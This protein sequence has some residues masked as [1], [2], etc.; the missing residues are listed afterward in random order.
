MFINSY[1]T[2]VIFFLQKTGLTV[3][4]ITNACNLLPCNFEHISNQSDPKYYIFP[5]TKPAMKK[6]HLK[7]VC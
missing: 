3:F 7:D 2:K 5:L 4:K 1:L 6:M